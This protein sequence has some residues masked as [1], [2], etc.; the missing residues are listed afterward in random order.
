MEERVGER[1]PFSLACPSPRSCLT[2]EEIGARQMYLGL[3]EAARQ[4]GGLTLA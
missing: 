4:Y 3:Q 1:R 2:G